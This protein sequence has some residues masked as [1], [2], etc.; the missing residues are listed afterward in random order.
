M[1][2]NPYESP[3]PQKREINFAVRKI[4]R[5]PA[6]CLFLVALFG[7]VVDAAMATQTLKDAYQLYKWNDVASAI[8]LVMSTISLTVVHLIVLVGAVD[9]HTRRSFQLARAAAILA[10]LPICSPVVVLGIPFG[11]WAIIALSRRGVEEAFEES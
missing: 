3:A 6:R 2:D 9:M 11:I 8:G 1:T 5:W 7:L 4:V 10:M